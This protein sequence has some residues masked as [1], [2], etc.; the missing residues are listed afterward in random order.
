MKKLITLLLITFTL[1]AFKSS[2]EFNIV[3]KWK[4]NDKNEMGYMVFQKNGYAYILINGKKIGGKEF[5]MN[6]V[7]MSMSY[8]M[9]YSKKPIEYDFIITLIDENITQ[10]MPGILEIINND[11]IKVEL[12]FDGQRP[13]TFGQSTEEVIFNRVKE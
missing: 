13:T 6:G 5:E 4:A 7:K 10:N 3:G 1:V 11:K 2:S 12:G 8:S 9:D